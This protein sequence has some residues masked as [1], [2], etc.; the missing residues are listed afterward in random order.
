[1]ESLSPPQ[2][3]SI[4]PLRLIDTVMRG[5]AVEE[6]GRSA[7]PEKKKKKGFAAVGKVAAGANRM[8]RAPRPN[9]FEEGEE[10]GRR[11]SARGPNRGGESGYA[12]TIDGL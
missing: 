7:R 9:L 1:M 12:S 5:W 2:Y 8:A 4:L 3:Y 10:R 11:G 6:R